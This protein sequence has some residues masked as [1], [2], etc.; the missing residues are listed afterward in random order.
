M[1]GIQIDL[2]DLELKRRTAT[3]K[4]R[5]QVVHTLSEPIQRDV[6]FNDLPKPVVRCE[7]PAGQ[8]AYHTNYMNYLVLCHGR[9]YG[10][11]VSPETLWFTVLSELAVHIKKN[12]EKYR[13]VFTTSDEKQEVS[14]LSLDPEV[15]P[16]H[17]LMAHTAALCPVDADLFIPAFSTHTEQSLVASKALFLDAVSPYYSY[18]MYMCGIPKISLQ[19]TKE[20][21]QLFCERLEALSEILSEASDYLHRVGSRVSLIV[22][23]YEEG[24]YAEMWKDF[25]HLENCGSGSQVICKGWYAE[26]FFMEY[27]KLAQP[28]NFPTQVAKVEYKNL[29]T[30]LDYVMF[31]G[32]FSSRFE[33]GFLVPEFGFSVELVDPLWEDQTPSKPGVYLMQGIKNEAEG[34][35]MVVRLVENQSQVVGE[36]GLHVVMGPTMHQDRFQNVNVNDVAAMWAPAPESFFPEVRRKDQQLWTP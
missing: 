8:E 30:G 3:I 15:M 31:Q 18:S 28:C 16:I 9:H 17:I 7:V 14:V 24:H 13:S 10:V 12:A 32:L 26:E 25:F 1:N 22:Q 36:G 20:D 19:G 6:W 21:W 2:M 23:G 35:V 29:D 11:V 27:P 33:D 5:D 4:D 34:A